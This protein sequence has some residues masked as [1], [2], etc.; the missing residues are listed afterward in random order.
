[1]N[2]DPDFQAASEGIRHP[3][4]VIL[5]PGMWLC[6]FASSQGALHQSPWWMSSDDFRKLLFAT[7][8]SAFNFKFF[9]RI[10]LAVKAEWSNMDKLIIATVKNQTA[11]WAGRGRTMKDTMPNGM[12]FIYKPPANLMQIYIPGMVVREKDPKSGYNL[13][14]I[15]IHSVN[16]VP[17]IGVGA[18]DGE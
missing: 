18:L 8:N 9:A 5:K 6:R 14:N 13:G 16:D 12:E 11:V 7:Q 17:P 10:W 3:Q 2:T 4:Q 15:T 1:M